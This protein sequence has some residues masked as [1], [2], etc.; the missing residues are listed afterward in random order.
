MT[1]DTRDPTSSQARQVNPIDVAVGVA[2]VIWVVLTMWSGIVTGGEG[3]P[4]IPQTIMSLAL[5]TAVLGHM[6]KHLGVK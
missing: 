5:V 1:T 2:C 3:L 6:L 4:V